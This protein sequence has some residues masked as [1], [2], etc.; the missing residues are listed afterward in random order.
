MLT[1]GRVGELCLAPLTLA[2]VSLLYTRSYPPLDIGQ[3]LL[4]PATCLALA[5][6]YTVDETGRGPAWGRSLF[7][8]NAEFGLGM[9]LASVQ[10]RE[11]L[12][13]KVKAA[14]AGEAEVPAAMATMLQEWVEHFDD[15]EVRPYIYI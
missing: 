5:N 10:R 11:A 6:R 2:S 14:L 4:K 13:V 12:Q 1:F 8:D 9:A 3:S 7:E 15:A